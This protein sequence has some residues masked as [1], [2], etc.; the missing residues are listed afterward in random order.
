MMGSLVI[1]YLAVGG[2]YFLVA[3]WNSWYVR[4]TIDIYPNSFWP[5]EAEQERAVSAL[6]VFLTPVWPLVVLAAL[7]ASAWSLVQDVLDYYFKSNRKEGDD[8]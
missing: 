6:M 5:G 1:T 3:V 4:S 2:V 7:V 8:R